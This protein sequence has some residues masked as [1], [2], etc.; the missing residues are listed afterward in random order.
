KGTDFAA[1]AGTA[2]KSLQSGKVQIA[3]YSKT[4]GNWVVIK[5]DDGTV[6]KYMHM[7]NTPSVKTGQSVKAGQTIGK[8]GSTGNSTGN[9][10]HLQIEQNGKTIDPEKYM[11]GI[12]TSISDASQAEAERQQGI[13]QAKSDLLSLQGDISS[14]NDQIQELQYELVQS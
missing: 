14:V 10:L 7:L 6:A 2:I 3:G 9:H 12:G 8:V 1:K 11:Q 13:A 4:A 5:Q